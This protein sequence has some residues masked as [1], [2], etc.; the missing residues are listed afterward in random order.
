MPHIF[1]L[2]EL[3]SD[4]STRLE[5][6]ESSLLKFSGRILDIE[7]EIKWILVSLS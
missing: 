3:L 6:V 5:S 2:M 1:S 4:L 7:R